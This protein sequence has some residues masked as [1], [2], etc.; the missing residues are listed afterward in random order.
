MTYNGIPD[1]DE[2]GSLPIQD[3]LDISRLSAVFRHTNTSY[4]FLWALALLR[5][6]SGVDQISGKISLRNLASGMLDSAC[7][8]FYVFQLRSRRDDKIQELFRQLD[9]S[10]K[11]EKRVL[12]RQRGGVFFESSEDIP[13]S[14]VQTLTNYVSKLFLAPFFSEIIS[15]LAGTR[16]F[17][18]ISVLA[19]EHFC[20]D[21]PPLYRFLN[22]GDTIEIHPMWR[23]YMEDNAAIL[24]SWILWHW[25]RYM[26]RTN[27]YVPAIVIKLDESATPNTTKQRKFWKQVLES[28]K[29]DCFCIYTGEKIVANRFSLDHYIPWSFVAHDEM[30]NL[31]PVS[32]EGNEIK[33]SNIPMNS[34]Y[35]ENFFKMQMFSI[36]QL[37]DVYDK[38]KWEAL[39]ES[40]SIDL[41]LDV[42][43][44]IPTRAALRKALERA[45]VP[46]SSL[47]ETHGF[48]ADWTFPKQR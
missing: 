24:K 1:R 5:F 23:K 7:R 44:R 32:V 46:L 38:R 3:G 18:R 28:E 47:A 36:E 10:P 39:F 33:S 43:E 25:A 2:A 37:H 41:N 12:L 13:D 17:S 34:K 14:M 16:R 15:G 20:D 21:S 45:I 8:P 6:C 29:K 42:V 19:N 35:F 30:W 9:R 31:V 48:S 40:Y 22:E 26:Q 27:P 11:W 4:K